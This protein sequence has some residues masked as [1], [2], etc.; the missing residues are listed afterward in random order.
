MGADSFLAAIADFDHLPLPGAVFELDGTF[1]AVNEAAARFFLTPKAQ[2][3]GRKA[4][5]TA[6]G[7]E[8]YWPEIVAGAQQGEYNGELTMATPLGPRVMHYVAVQRVHEGRAVILTLAIEVTPLDG[9]SKPRVESL[10]LVA[11]GIAHGFNNQLVS[12]LAEASSAREE[13]N[14]PGQVVEA[15]RR[16]EGAA[17]RM[18]LLTRQLLAYAGRGRFVTEVIDPDALVA[19]MQSQLE[20][21]VRDDAMLVMAVGQTRAAIEVDR[22]LLQEVV[23]N[24]VANASESLRPTGGTISVSTSLVSRDSITWWQLEVADDGI[25]MDSRTVTRVFD[26]FF[27]TKIDRHGLG[28]SAVHGIVRR[29]G[30][31]IVVHSEV[32]KGTRFLVRLPLVSSAVDLRPRPARPTAERVIS[33]RGTS[34]LIADDEPS[35]RATIRRLLER[36][37]ATVVVASDGDE[38]AARLADR[39]YT[40]V[41][42]DVMMPGKTGYQ[43]LPI[44][45]NLQPHAKVMLMSGFTE[46]AH[47]AGEDEP[48]A[49]L[50]KPFTAK[51]MDDAVDS[52]LGR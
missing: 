13:P 30:G 39:T 40:L 44:V 49:F 37:G 15:L 50:E 10:G 46:A 6:P 47:A 2:F 22:G 19:A 32:G 20:A 26:P 28:L 4:W 31:E 25:G 5:D 33:L 11:G 42:L 12:V 8:H 17:Q 23:V 18:A 3:H 7:A 52:V 34:V 51:Q 43:L 24:L 48:D 16:I 41:L 14:L 21:S 35:V 29:L 36:R 38:A 27:T 1:V 45:R 9:D